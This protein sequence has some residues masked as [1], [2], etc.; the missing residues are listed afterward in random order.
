MTD[1]NLLDKD[2]LTVAD[3]I[4]DANQAPYHTILEVWREVLKPAAAERLKRITP[5]W[6]TRVIAT[7][8][9]LA[10]ADMPAFR[11]LYFGSILTLA[12][13]LDNEITEDD[14]CLNLH[15]PEEDLEHNSAH[16]LN[17]LISW[18]M[19]F[20]QW[21]VEWDATDPKAAIQVAALGEVHKMFFDPQGLTALL[22]QI[23]FQFTDDD[24]D[25]MTTALQSLLVEEGDGE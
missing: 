16:Y 9:G 6:A 17:V 25:L 24:R 10:Y 23:N 12:E 22:D 8:S 18:Q 19:Q 5:Q 13:I 11:D 3:I 15:T 21:E 20:M 4:E 7:Y 14:E 1:K 2:D